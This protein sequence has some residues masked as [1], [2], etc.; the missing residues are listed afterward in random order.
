MLRWWRQIEWKYD[1]KQVLFCHNAHELRRRPSKAAWAP[2]FGGARVCGQLWAVEKGTVF[3]QDFT[4]SLCPPLGPGL[5]NYTPFFLLSLHTCIFLRWGYLP[6]RCLT[7]PFIHE[8]V[9]HRFHHVTKGGKL[10]AR[11]KDMK[12]GLQVLYLQWLHIH[13]K[14]V[15]KGWDN[16]TLHNS[17]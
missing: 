16:K 11:W 17:S 2:S 6:A 8:Q 13:C 7:G 9:T 10:R 14:Y 5:W 15:I 1:C 4:S 3:T 12:R